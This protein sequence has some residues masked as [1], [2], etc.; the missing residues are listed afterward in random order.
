MIIVDCFDGD[1]MEMAEAQHDLYEGENLTPDLWVFGR[2]TLG[3]I[4]HACACRVSEIAYRN[5]WCRRNERRLLKCE[6]FD[7]RLLQAHHDF[8]AAYYRW[9]IWPEVKL[10]MP[11][12]AVTEA[13][14]HRWRVL[15]W[16][17]YLH[18]E[19]PAM[20]EEDAIAVAIGKILVYHNFDASDRAWEQL[21]GLLV[22]RY[23]LECVAHTRRAPK[24]HAG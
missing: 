10:L 11:A 7:H 1:D 17:D 12:I 8:M 21:D 22:K 16:R 20:L 15:R 3:Y 5:E 24:Q 6:S 19:V 23:G 18:R 4:V 14:K 2:T 13:D 9:L